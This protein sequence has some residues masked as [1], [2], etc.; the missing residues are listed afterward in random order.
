MHRQ[1][2]AVDVL[3]ECVPNIAARGRRRRIV[4]GFVVLAV[5]IA[6]FVA[7]AR[8]HAGAALFLVLAPLTA[9]TALFF[10]QAKEKT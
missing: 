9:Y 7:L 2:M 3:S 4:K 1:N 5:T 6:V 10:F 8:R